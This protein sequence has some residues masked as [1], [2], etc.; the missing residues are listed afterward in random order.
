MSYNNLMKKVIVGLSGGVDSSFALALLKEN[1]YEVI[2]V[3]MKIWS[4][5]KILDIKKKGGCYG[6]SEVEEIKDAENVCK[7]LNVPFFVFDLSKE[8][9]DEI[10]N[11]VKEEYKIGRTPNPCVLCNK[12]IKFDLLLKMAEREGI[13]FDYF[14][15]GHY[16]RIEKENK[17][18]IL[19]KGVDEKKDQSYFLWKLT[20]EQ[21]SK[22]LFPL[23]N[24]KKE[25]VR[26]E[27]KKMNLPV[28][29][30]LESQDFF[31]GDLGFLIPETEVGYIKNLKGNIIG[32][33]KGISKYTIG[34]RRGLGISSNEPL[35]VVKIDPKENTIYV[36]EKKDLFFKKFLV[37][38]LNWV[39][40]EKPPKN[41]ECDVKIRYKHI[42]AK[43]KISIKDL[44]FAIVEFKVPQLSITP[45]QSA[46]FYDREV[47]LGGAIIDEIYE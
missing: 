36:G 9:K 1:G 6:P 25:D 20:K 43:A 38:N 4:G 5:E 41:M 17:R 33:H 32:K 13:E 31:E 11:Y 23:G 47:L 35:Y 22:V 7:L 44:N 28:V 21:I 16:S 8:Y 26:K 24:F 42:P 15:T 27:A 37:K 29:E 2:G 12:K 46:V 19:K 30:K 40:I 18:F 34:Q 39:S 14:A 3:S 45:G 10:L